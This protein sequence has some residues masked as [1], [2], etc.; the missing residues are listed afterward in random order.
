MFS[1]IARNVRVKD[2]NVLRKKH[3]CIILLTLN[4]IFRADMVNYLAKDNPDKLDDNESDFDFSH[5]RDRIFR[6]EHPFHAQ[7]R[8]RSRAEVY[9]P[10]P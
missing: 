7:T 8:I 3:F 2:E 6:K 1:N 9:G 4:L 10:F 5:R